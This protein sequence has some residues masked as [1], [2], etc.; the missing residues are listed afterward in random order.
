MRWTLAG[1][2]LLALGL[3]LGVGAWL[4]S[5]EQSLQALPDQQEYLALA[6]GLLSG[7]GLRFYDERFDDTV[8]AFRTPGYP[9][10]VAL[11]GAQVRAVRVAQAFVDTLTVLAAWV[12]A[13]RWLSSRQALIAAVLVALHPFLI[14][15]SALLLTETVFTAMLAW[16]AALLCRPRSSRPRTDWLI[17]CGGILLLALTALVRPSG[18]LLAPLLA[19]GAVYAG[20]TWSG[21][22][23]LPRRRAYPLELRAALAAAVGAGLTILVLS[24]WAWRNHRVLGSWVWTTTNAGHTL[25]DGFNPA[26]TGASDLS[27]LR[28][29]GELRRMNEVERS[30]YLAAL[31]RRWAAEHP[32]QSVKLAAVK[33]AR[34]WSPVPLSAQ[35]GGDD[36]YVGAALLYMLPLYVLVSI[37]LLRLALPRS[38]KV[39]LLLPAVYFTATHAVSVGSLR[40]RIPAD[41]PMAVIAASALARPSEA[42]GRPAE[43]E[44]TLTG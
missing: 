30:D 31:A 23:N 16:G 35:Y 18:A 8:V 27:G 7:E 41:V 17:R 11:F 2:L 37:G 25:Y 10:F 39:F 13:R 24:A 38:A 4:P 21:S 15:F 14:Y 33:V 6:R 5:D 19:A 26:A 34:L 20:A 36:R 9:L 28:T 1:I 22:P 42:S 12:L 32:G 40:Y 3:R 29:M 43:D 44:P